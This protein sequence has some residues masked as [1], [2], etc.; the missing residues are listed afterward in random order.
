[1]EHELT[2]KITTT[3]A[4][5]SANAPSHR[6]LSTVEKRIKGWAG[7]RPG[8]NWSR[9]PAA[10]PLFGKESSCSFYALLL[11]ASHERDNP[12]KGSGQTVKNPVTNPGKSANPPESR[13][14]FDGGGF[15]FG[16]NFLNAATVRE[17][18]RV[19]SVFV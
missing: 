15:G 18:A 11:S 14:M 13:L 3:A 5:A 7:G 2:D 10:S 16:L 17:C 8:K 1:V 19:E 4:T 6:R 9:S 12:I